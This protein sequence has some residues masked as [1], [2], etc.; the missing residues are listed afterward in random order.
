MEKHTEAFND[1]EDMIL[2]GQGAANESMLTGES[3]AVFKEKGQWLLSGSYLSE[4]GV[5]RNFSDTMPLAPPP[6]ARTM[7]TIEL[8][9]EMTSTFER[10]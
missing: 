3:R 9:E 7:F 6:W 2:D 8:V 10:S 4:G 5:S 1:D